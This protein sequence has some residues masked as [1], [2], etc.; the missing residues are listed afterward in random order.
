MLR[1]PLE[2]QLDPWGPIATRG[3]SVERSVKYIDDKKGPLTDLSGSACIEY[4]N[5]SVAALSNIII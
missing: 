3:R 4:L 1:T 2:K 5:F